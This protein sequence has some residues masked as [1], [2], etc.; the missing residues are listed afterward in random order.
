MSHVIIPGTESEARAI[1]GSDGTPVLVD[2]YAEWCGPCKA[3][4]PTLERFAADTYFDELRHAI[5]TTLVHAV[6]QQ[7]AGSC[8]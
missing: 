3:F 6:Q 4:A 8:V 1:L 7:A 5:G 2:F